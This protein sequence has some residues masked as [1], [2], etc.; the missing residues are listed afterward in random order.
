M[1]E[2]HISKSNKQQQP[3]SRLFRYRYHGKIVSSITTNSHRVSRPNRIE[4]HGKAIMRIA[5]AFNLTRD[6]L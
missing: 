3:L 6:G 4:Y 5:L 2:K 1:P